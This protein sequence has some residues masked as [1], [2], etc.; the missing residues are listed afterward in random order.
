M[1]G[2]TRD[3]TAEANLVRP[4][5]QAQSETTRMVPFSLF[6]DSLGVAHGDHYVVRVFS[7]T[8]PMCL[9]LNRVCSLL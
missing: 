2:L 5:S 9:F 6:K 4:N 1:T 8:C 3:G 7:S